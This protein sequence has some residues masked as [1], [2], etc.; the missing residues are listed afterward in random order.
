VANDI[1]GTADPDYDTTL[2][3]RTRDVERAKTLLREANF[4]TGK[5]YP[6]ATKAE[7]PGEVESARVL[8]TQLAEIG[9]K[10]EVVVQESNAFYDQTWLHA[11]LYTVSWGTNDSTLFYADKLLSSRSN[12]NET[13]F[14]DAEFDAATASALGARDT[15][16]YAAA[17]KTLQRIQYERGGYLVWGM[18]DGIDIAS[19]KVRDLPTLGG[20]ARV[21]LERA[22][23]E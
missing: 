14:K 3:Q 6:L 23:L 20:F 15:A 10:L 8:A 2:P 1:L 18:A 9:V 12:R 7:A 22:W 13:A 19:A 16:E 4:D 5:T 11:P 17:C 21:Q